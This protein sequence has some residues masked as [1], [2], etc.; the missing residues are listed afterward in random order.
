MRRR[1]G[2]ELVCS[3]CMKRRELEIGLGSDEF[4]SVENT[5]QAIG[6]LD[7]PSRA[8][9]KGRLPPKLAAP[10]ARAIFMAR[11]WAIGP[12]TQQNVDTTVDAARLEARA[13]KPPLVKSRWSRL[14]AV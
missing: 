12:W 13:T 7:D 14:F 10:Q 2:G 8:A 5:L 4:G 6:S 9:S 3:I 11:A 1:S